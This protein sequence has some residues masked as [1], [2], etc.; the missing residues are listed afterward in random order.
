MMRKFEPEEV[1][2]M[3]QSM[4]QYFPELESIAV[5]DEMPEAVIDSTMVDSMVPEEQ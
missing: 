5:P 3:I 2:D 1:E 4:V